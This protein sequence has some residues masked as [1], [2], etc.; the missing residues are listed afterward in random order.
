[1]EMVSGVATLRVKYPDRIPVLVHSKLALR[2]HKFLCPRQ[3][4]MHS[5]I[6]V[7]RRHADLRST[8]ALFLIANGVIPMMRTTVEELDTQLCK[9]GDLLNVHVMK[10]SVFG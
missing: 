3:L 2:R 7:V 10:E 5:L 4:T 1:M 6:E 8:D 9:D